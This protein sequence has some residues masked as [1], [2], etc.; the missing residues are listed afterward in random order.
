M[1][2]GTRPGHVVAEPGPLASVAEVPLSETGRLEPGS[3]PWG[4]DPSGPSS[5]LGFL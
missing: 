1:G 2:L 3:D 4:P 5:L